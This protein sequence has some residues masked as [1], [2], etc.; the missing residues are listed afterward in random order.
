[1]VEN[2]EF[3]SNGFS[4]KFGNKLSS[5]GDIKYREGNKE[6]TELT[7]GIGMGGLGG[8]LE[9]P[10]S[11]NISYIASYRRSYLNLLADAINA[12]GMPSYNDFQGKVTYK[13]NIY[14]TYTILSINGSSMYD[15]C[16]LYTSPSPRDLST[17]RMPSSA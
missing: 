8:F 3:Y 4:A 17:S 16:L 5:F 1:M 11:K 14:N 7:L 6:T 15:S 2:L 9:G 10:F 13:P 12:G